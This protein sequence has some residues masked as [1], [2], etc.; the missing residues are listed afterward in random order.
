MATEN[1]VKEFTFEAGAAVTARLFGKLSSGKVV[2]CGTQGERS[3]GIIGST[4]GSGEG[5]SLKW[6]KCL[7]TGGANVTAG[8]AVMTNAAGKAI[9]ATSTNQALGIALEAGAS[10][11]DFMVLVFPPSAYTV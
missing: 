5:T 6:G 1:I 9:A 4:V 8:A 3:H 2:P 7:V 10:D 11:V